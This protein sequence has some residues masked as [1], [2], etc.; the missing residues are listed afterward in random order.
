MHSDSIN[1]AVGRR[2][3]QSEEEIIASRVIEL[4]AWAMAVLTRD[5]PNSADEKAVMNFFAPD[6][7]L[8]PPTPPPRAPSSLAR[9]ERRGSLS[10]SL[11][12]QG[13]GLE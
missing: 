13:G 2:Y 6:G 10:Q 7:S 8:P 11:N 9:K 1:A 4:S 12:S 5:D 3:F